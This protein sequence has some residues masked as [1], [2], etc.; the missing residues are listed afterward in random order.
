[1]AE[2]VLALDLPSPR[3]ALKLI[4]TLPEL[5]WCKVGP[6]LF[7]RDG[8]NLV[9]ELKTRGIRV[10][11]DLK[12]HDIPHQVSGAVTAAVELGVDLA[13]LHAVGGTDMIE[14][15]AAVK[16]GLRLAAIT[17]LTSHNA[18]SYAA[19]TGR[20]VAEMTSGPG[21]AG[22]VVRLAR[23]ATGA[24]ADAIVCSPHEVGRVR[25]AVPAGTWLVV[26]GIRAPGQEAGDQKRAAHPSEA[27]QGGA[28]HLVVG[29][30]IWEAKEPR[31]VY[32][33]LCG[34][35]S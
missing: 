12:W 20:T 4:D 2:L 18:E 24:G 27:I 19:V 11:L 26:P 1:V 3:E 35:I 25:D 13:S 31:A 23:L 10:F 9:R 6:T 8:P 15:A 5:E 29:R 28:T 33:Q 7:V 14:A 30:P 17:V 32:E 34:L 22:E 16:G 21:L